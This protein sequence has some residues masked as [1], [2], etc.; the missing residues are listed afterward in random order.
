MVSAG[1]D[2]SS[3]SSPEML[4]PVSTNGS[5]LCRHSQPPLLSHGSTPGP[6]AACTEK[7]SSSS[8]Y[9]SSTSQRMVEQCTH[10]PTHPA[11]ISSGTSSAG[12]FVSDHQDT[13]KLSMICLLMLVV[14]VVAASLQPDETAC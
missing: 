7:S 10:T 6:M 4:Q 11:C 1:K 3:H 2:N 14:V 5:S 9:S 12:Q 8:Q 13:G